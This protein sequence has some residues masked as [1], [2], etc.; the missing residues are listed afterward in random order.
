M[1]PEN[2][3]PALRTGRRSGVFEGSSSGRI[4]TPTS[5][6]LQRYT[7]TGL[8]RPS[9]L[10]PSQARLVVDPAGVGRGGGAR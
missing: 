8:R 7:A 6:F 3:T 1:S 4:D 5:P 2:G 9:R 10:R